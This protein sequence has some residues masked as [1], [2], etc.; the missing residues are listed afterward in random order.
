MHK[1]DAHGCQPLYMYVTQ[2]SWAIKYRACI[3]MYIPTDMQH[4]S[5]DLDHEEEWGYLTELLH[6]YSRDL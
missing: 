3:E 2:Y 4:S 6:M 5:P 1:T